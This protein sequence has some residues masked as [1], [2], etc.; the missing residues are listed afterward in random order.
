MITL[1]NVTSP[2]ESQSEAGLD[3]LT[4]TVSEGEVVSVVGHSSWT[5]R[6]LLGVLG[7]YSDDWS[8]E[9]EL[10]GHLVHRLDDQERAGLRAELVGA[11]TRSAPLVDCLTVEENLEIPLSYRGIQAEERSALIEDALSRLGVQSIRDR[12]VDS[13]PADQMQLVGIAKALVSNPRLVLLE[14]PTRNLS[15][16]QIRLVGRE[17]E[18]LRSTGCIIVQSH[19]R[20]QSGL[21]ADRT[22]ELDAGGSFKR[23][24]RQSKSPRR[25]LNS[26]AGAW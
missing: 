3:A 16:L 2:L 5:R 11:M 20:M 21:D 9:Y 13:L 17:V 12:E 1:R 23:E 7:L 6:R 4:F 14:D 8:G 24:S 15:Q 26:V 22:M 18:R 19:D 10:F 25:R